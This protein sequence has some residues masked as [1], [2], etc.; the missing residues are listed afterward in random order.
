MID[1]RAKAN[2]EPMTGGISSKAYPA[3]QGG[4]DKYEEK[5]NYTKKKKGEE[6]LR[7]MKAIAYVA[8]KR[9]H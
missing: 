3:A 1:A 4:K 6:H 5:I 7:G 2:L 9:M 8:D